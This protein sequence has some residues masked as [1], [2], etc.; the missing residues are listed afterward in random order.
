MA[1]DSTRG[2]R[3]DLVL[4]KGKT[5]ERVFTS[6]AV[7]VE[8]GVETRLPLNLN[9]GTLRAQCRRKVADAAPAFT[10]VCSPVT[11]A[12]GKWRLA[13]SAVTLAD[14]ALVSGLCEEDPK[15][16]YERWDVEFAYND[17]RVVEL[18]YGTVSL[19]NEATR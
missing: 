3:L 13:V 2:Q 15:A 5:Y 19:L 12:E 4:V 9:D 1:T 7:Y 10:L 14:P 11:P 8:D 18:Y 17:G 6:T 16:L